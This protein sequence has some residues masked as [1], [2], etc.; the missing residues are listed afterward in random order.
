MNPFTKALRRLTA[1]LGLVAFVFAQSV[2]AATMNFPGMLAGSGKAASAS[3][4]KAKGVSGQALVQVVAPCHDVLA[5]LAA[6]LAAVCKQHC[7]ADTLTL[8]HAELP[9]LV[10]VPLIAWMLEE[11]H[12]T[13]FSRA[14][15]AALAIHGGAPPLYLTSA[16]LRV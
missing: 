9:P 1:L 5:E 12:Q 3:T 11:P 4:V 8:D 2:V 15:I 7:Q 10:I 13:V 16:R 14:S 6:N